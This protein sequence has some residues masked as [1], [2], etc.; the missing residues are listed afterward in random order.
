[1]NGFLDGDPPTV[2]AA[3]QLLSQFPDG[4]LIRLLRTAGT[5]VVQPDGR[6]LKGHALLVRPADP[7]VTAHQMQLSGTQRLHALEKQRPARETVVGPGWDAA[8]PQ[9]K[10]ALAQRLDLKHGAVFF[11]QTLG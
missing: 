5:A 11:R 9:V 3:V 2:S 1:M 7:Q 6:F 10:D 8:T 4:A